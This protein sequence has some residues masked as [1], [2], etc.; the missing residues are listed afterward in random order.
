MATM[1]QEDVEMSD[2]AP[3]VF[4]SALRCP[5]ACAMRCV[6]PPYDAC[7]LPPLIPLISPS[8][9]HPTHLSLAHSLQTTSQAHSTGPTTGQHPLLYKPV[10]IYQSLIVRILP[11]YYN[12]VSTLP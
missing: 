10:V 8:L 3:A 9:T 1:T 7:P 5:A 11:I 2:T 6:V 4:L 12:L